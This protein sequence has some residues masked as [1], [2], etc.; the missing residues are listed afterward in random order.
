MIETNAAGAL[1]PYSFIQINYKTKFIYCIRKQLEVITNDNFQDVIEL[2][3]MAPKTF[4]D[5]ANIVEKVSLLI[6]I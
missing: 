3:E 5:L 1:I 6:F 2:G 4:D